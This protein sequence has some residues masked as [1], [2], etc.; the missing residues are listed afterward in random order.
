MY[1]LML[2]LRKEYAAMGEFSKTKKIYKLREKMKRETL[3]TKNFTRI[4]LV[5]VLSIIGGEVMNLPLS[6]L[7]F[8][9]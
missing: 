3:W 1:E 6:L 5:S 2:E 8:Y 9:G 4:T 7:V